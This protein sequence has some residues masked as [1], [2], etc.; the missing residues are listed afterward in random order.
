MSGDTFVLR[1][2]P[3]EE[4]DRV[5]RAYHYAR[6]HLSEAVRPTGESLADHSLEVA[7]VLQEK[8][9]S[10][11]IV[12]AALLHAFPHHA[13]GAILL[14]Q[15]PITSWGEIQLI[16]SLS[17]ACHSHAPLHWPH[18]S[19]DDP[20]LSLLFAA[21]ALNDVRHM[22]RL[23]PRERR[24]LCQKVFRQVSLFARS[25]KLDDWAEEME[26]RCFIEVQP[27]AART[28]KTMCDAT[29]TEDLEAL[30]QLALPLQEELQRNRLDCDVQYRVKGLYSTY[31]KLRTRFCSL[32]NLHD[33]LAVRVLCPN[34]E[35]CFDVLG[36]VHR[37][38]QPLPT[39]FKD[40]I[41][42][43]KQNGYRSL[44]TVVFSPDSP[45]RK[46]V[47]IQI[48]S[49]DMHWNSVYGPAEH[50]RYKLERY[51]VAS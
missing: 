4:K 13:H 25:Q 7:T 5:Q 43:P 6:S 29:R 50:V 32:H 40:Y 17:S 8:I 34:D 15:A 47:E 19:I 37:M 18:G 28:L 46:M 49:D 35:T 45:A 10:P 27:S 1:R 36:R 41:S 9:L 21:H 20:R 23:Q 2:G 3:Q 38:Y 14:D 11:S 12:S 24:K 31:R 51:P 42:N 22:D 16:C 30:R 39:H 33:R 44:H 26:N 48:R